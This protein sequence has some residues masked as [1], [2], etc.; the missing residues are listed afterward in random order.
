MVKIFLPMHGINFSRSTGRND[1]FL[2]SPDSLKLPEAFCNVLVVNFVLFYV[3]RAPITLSSMTIIICDGEK[4]FSGR[5]ILFQAFCCG[6]QQAV[7]DNW[8]LLKFCIWKDRFKN[9]ISMDRGSPKPLQRLTRK[10]LYIFRM[11]LSIYIFSWL[12]E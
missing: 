3:H 1:I 9:G 8:E 11:F 5:S 6:S 4:Q 10:T 7:L 2:F 12:V